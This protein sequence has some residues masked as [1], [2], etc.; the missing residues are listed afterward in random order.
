[1]TAAPPWTAERVVSPKEALA[2]V[3][4]HHPSLSPSR[5][6]PLGEGWDNTAYLVDGTW[7]FRFPRRE[8]AVEL[9][10]IEAR[11]LP[12]IADRLPLPIPKPEL[13][14]EPT[15]AYPWPFV[16]Y[17]MLPGRTAD[18]AALSSDRKAELAEP[19]GEFLAAL[20]EIDSGPTGAPLDDQTRTDTRRHVPI[21][22]RYLEAVITAG[23]LDDTRA[24]A[25]ILEL[26][27]DELPPRRVLVHADL[28]V[29]HV[30]VDEGGRAC[31]V[32]DWGD[33]HVGHPGLDFALAFSLLPPTARE[34]FRRAYGRPIDDESWA[35]GRQ[36]GLLY[37]AVLAAYG[38]DTREQTLVDEGMQALRWVVE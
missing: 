33:V 17:R 22:E 6:E 16:G 23:M 19:L 30:L 27:H 12:A 11:V 4:D 1:M 2:L 18:R 26:A 35:L 38:L 32:I 5:I 20:H 34:R 10:E 28:Y 14:A 3:R 8:I 36:R 29:R 37:G 9:I 13:L 25:P 24:F 21:V 31:G 7:V 15:E